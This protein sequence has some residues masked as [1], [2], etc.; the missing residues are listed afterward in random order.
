MHVGL[1]TT[2]RGHSTVERS[3]WPTTERVRVLQFAATHGGGVATHVA[4]LARGLNSAKYDVR[5]LCPPAGDFRLRLDGSGIPLDHLPFAPELDLSGDVRLLRPLVEYLRRYRFHI[6]HTHSTKAGLWGRLAARLCGV[7]VVLYTAN[8][9]RF[10]RYRRGSPLWGLYVGLEWV[11]GRVGSGIVAAGPSE[12]SITGALRLAAPDR[13]F[14]VNNGVP[15]AEPLHSGRDAAVRRQLGLP[16]GRPLVVTIGRLVPQKDPLTFLDMAGRVVKARDDVVFVMVGDGELRRVTVERIGQLG[17]EDRVYVIPGTDRVPALLLEAD[18]FVMTSRYEGLS[19]AAAEAAALGC[20]MVVSDVPGLR[21][22]V[23]HDVSG[24][25]A[26]VGDSSAFTSA[27]LQLLANPGRRRAL[28][29]QAVLRVRRQFSVEGMIRETEAL[30]D[31]L[32]EAAPRQRQG[33]AHPDG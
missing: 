24:L 9:Y 20:A 23:Q 8:A 31:Q 11:L 22:L 12:A 29:E 5:V 3:G 18:V 16:D 28:G 17:I 1:T 26:P 21:D 14:V 30:Y 7:P 13:Q 27:V 32:L 10:L 2:G 19:Y 15:F 4:T 6:V 33:V 25:L